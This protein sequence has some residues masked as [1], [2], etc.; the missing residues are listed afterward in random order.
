MKSQG[1]P[2]TTIALILIVIVVLAVVLLFFFEGFS[3][4]KSNLESTTD[5]ATCKNDCL[6]AQNLAKDTWKSATNGGDCKDSADKS[7]L[8]FC[9][10]NCDDSMSCKI[11]FDDG[12]YCYVKC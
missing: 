12:S 2:M 3:G 5:V 9:T 7:K 1:L 6:Q 4:P 11:N 8:D 10:D